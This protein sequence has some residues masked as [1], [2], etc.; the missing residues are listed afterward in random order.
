MGGYSNSSYCTLVK[1]H[2]AVIKVLSA[3]TCSESIFKDIFMQLMSNF[4][5][6]N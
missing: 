4:G 2:I 1:M 5:I 6:T 3:Q